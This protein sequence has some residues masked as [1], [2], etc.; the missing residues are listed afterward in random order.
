LLINLE[1]FHE[2]TS[3]TN[4]SQSNARKPS[5]ALWSH[6][7]LYGAIISN[8]RKPS[9]VLRDTRWPDDRAIISSM[10]IDLTAG[11]QLAYTAPDMT[12]SIHDFSNH[13]QVVIQ[14]HGYE[15]WQGESNLL[16][17]RSLIGRLSNTSYTNF[18]YNVEQVADHLAS[19]GI[20]AIPG[21]MR[22]IEELRGRQWIIQ[23]VAT[24]SVQNPQEARIRSRTDGSLSIR[25][26]RYSAAGPQ[27]NIIVDEQ[28]EEML[29]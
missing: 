1:S 20:R 9:S 29:E 8:A 26:S 19:R 6:H 18:R 27:E 21:Q 17:S 28:D 25:F 16:L 13:I 23:P 24:P 4:N 5:S 15:G 14:T 3:R 2:S 22:T 10:E 11:T 7:Q 12:L